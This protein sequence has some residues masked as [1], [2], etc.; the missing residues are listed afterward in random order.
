MAKPKAKEKEKKPN[1]LKGLAKGKGIAMPKPTPVVAAAQTPVTTAPAPPPREL[2]NPP[3]TAFQ[4]PGA[5]SKADQKAH[6]QELKGEGLKG[7]ALKQGMKTWRTAGREEQNAALRERLGP[8]AD[9]VKN[10][11]KFYRQLLKGKGPAFKKLMHLRTAEE[12]L[13]YAKPREAVE[14]E[15]TR[16]FDALGQ[17]DP[18]QAGSNI[19]VERDFQETPTF[20]NFQGYVNRHFDPATG[21]AE[22]LTGEE[23]RAI[24]GTGAHQIAAGFGQAEQ[25]EMQRLAAA[26]IDPRS[27]LGADSAM[28]L[29]AERRNA[30]ADL[31][32]NIVEQNLNRKQ[33]FE[34]YA[35]DTGARE[36]QRRQFD[37]SG[38]LRRLADVEGGMMDTAKLAE[39]RRQYDTSYT[40]SQR[41][42]K[43]ARE[44]A[45][46]AASDL[47]PTDFEK[48]MSGL[49]G[50]MK[51]LG[52]GGGGGGGGGGG[53]TQMASSMGGY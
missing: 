27:G 19:E 35:S 38:D 11:R 22:G 4:V 17:E 10:P 14:N 16:Q 28:K 30:E 48:A 43:L 53:M 21:E 41:Q 31:E 6:R 18:G 44:A 47:E 25:N 45:A 13:G 5:R 36:E 3:D 9:M 46:K 50:L 34:G 24:R 8:G 20:S 33:E 32:R 37:V 2:D 12:E 23:E 52:A 39:T 7:K 40:E 49:S 26:G 1:K 42:A 51:G 15:Y 29:G